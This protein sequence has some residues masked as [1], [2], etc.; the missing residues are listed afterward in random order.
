MIYAQVGQSE[1][2]RTLG[3]AV[4]LV[5]LA[6]PAGKLEPLNLACALPEDWTRSLL[7]NSD[8]SFSRNCS[9]PMRLA[10]SGKEHCVSWLVSADL[11]ELALVGNQTTITTTIAAMATND[12]PRAANERTK[13]RLDESFFFSLSTNS[14]LE[15]LEGNL[16]SLLE[17]IFINERA[18]LSN[19]PAVPVCDKP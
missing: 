8:L 17:G 16:F 19:G 9:S 12:N 13:H 14:N 5:H 3:P 4:A 2:L 18:V 15:E 7:W 11:S 10:S 1:L 6:R